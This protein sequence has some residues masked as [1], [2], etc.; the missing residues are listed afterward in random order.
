MS[1]NILSLCD[2]RLLF[3][4]LYF[5]FETMLNARNIFY[6]CPKVGRLFTKKNTLCFI[7]II[8]FN[9]QYWKVF[10][11]HRITE[12]QY[13][14]IGSYGTYE[15]EPLYHWLNDYNK[16]TTTTDSKKHGSMSCAAC[17]QLIC[18]IRLENCYWE[19]QSFCW[20]L[21]IFIICYI[22]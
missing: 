15:T 11:P 8:K 13:Y 14:K 4:K 7:L 19:L 6:C 2:M 3:N 17:M 9:K 1:N 21:L 5:Y 20:F 12:L 18:S 10:Q 22:Q 16:T